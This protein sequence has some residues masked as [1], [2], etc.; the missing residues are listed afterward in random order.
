MGGLCAG[1]IDQ[2]ELVKV[3]EVKVDTWIHP[4]MKTPQTLNLCLKR[5]FWKEKLETYS[6]I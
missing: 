2:Q 5:C 1:Q 6:V 4:Y 3:K